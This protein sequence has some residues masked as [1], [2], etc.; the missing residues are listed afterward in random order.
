MQKFK[1]YNDYELLYLIG[2][3]SE[4]ALYILI[5]KYSN[6]IEIKLREFKI[7]KSDYDD[8]FQECLMMLYETIK[9]YNPDSKKTFCR[10]FELLVSRR[11][12][13]LL[14][15]KRNT[16]KCFYDCDYEI[17]ASKIDIER[18]IIYQEMLDEV[19]EVKVDHLKSKILR[20]VLVDNNS[21]KNFAIG[22]DLEVR[23][24]YNH[25]YLLRSKLK[26]KINF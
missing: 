17:F 2:W 15:Q 18:K 7:R 10:F 22:N 25:I 26:K 20:E 11:I 24:V 13:N 9:I 23:E 5:C 6:F 1:N 16:L 4:E 14:R 21:I 8:F 3:Y 12:G 19:F